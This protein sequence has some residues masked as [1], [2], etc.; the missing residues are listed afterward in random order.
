[1]TTAS[2]L[3][4]VR[5][6]TRYKLAAIWA[7][8]MSC[9]IYAD[10]F[11]LYVPGKLRGMLAGRM[12]PLG[13]V[14]QGVLLGTSAMLAVPSLM[15]VLSVLLPGRL[16]RWLNVAVGLV[17]TAIQLLVVSSSGWAFY[18]GFGLLETALTALVVWTA[19]SWPKQAPH[20]VRGA[21]LATA[22]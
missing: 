15:I 9:Y 16:C 2:A 1:M 22:A 5:V 6:P 10:Y 7:S 20:A 3:D 21:A 18:I 12:E 14:S 8:V 13:A 19:W 11:E 17:Y 4:D